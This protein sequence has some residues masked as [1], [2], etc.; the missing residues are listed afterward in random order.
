VSLASAALPEGV[1]ASNNETKNDNQS[2][3]EI[4]NDDEIMASIP[5][6]DFNSTDPIENMITKCMY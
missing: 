2:V 1:L 6:L 4:N 3:S 5:H